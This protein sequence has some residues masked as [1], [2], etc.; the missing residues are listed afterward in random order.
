MSSG[1]RSRG[2]TK[3]TATAAA[4]AVAEWPDG[5]EVDAGS[6]P[7]GS[8]AGWLSGGRARSK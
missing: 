6:T 7:T 8:S 2:E 5:N 1:L 4:N 3:P